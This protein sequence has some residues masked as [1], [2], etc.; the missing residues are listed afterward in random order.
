MSSQYPEHDKLEAIKTES[1]AIGNFIEWLRYTKKIQFAKYVDTEH[2]IPVKPTKPVFPVNGD[3]VAMVL[4][5]TPTPTPAP[6]VYT[7]T[8][9]TPQFFNISD[10]LAEYFDIDLKKLEAEKLAMIEEIRK[11]TRKPNESEAPQT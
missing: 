8:E 11:H 1:Q 4:Y 3:R 6:E 9:F 5:D 7:T 10:I 2:E